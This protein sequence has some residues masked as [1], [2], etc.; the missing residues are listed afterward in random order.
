MIRLTVP[1]I[2]EDDLAAVREVVQSGLL[3]QGP[4]VAAFEEAIAN[5]V[6][7]RYAVAV[8][9]C[10]AALQM[11][12]LALDISR[13][14]IVVTTTYSWPATSNVIELC[15]AEPAFVDIRPDTFNIDPSALDT[16]L[17]QLMSTQST[18][19]RVKAVLPVH[20]FGQVADMPDILEIAGR[21]GLPVVEDAAC[22][23]GAT[24]HGR[25]AGSW[26]MMGCFSFHPRKAITT[27]EGGA[28]TTNDATLVRRLRALRNHGQDPD[29]SSPDFVMPGFNNRM[30]EF[31]G[32]LGSTQMSKLDRVVDAR[33]RAASRYDALLRGSTLKTPHVAPGSRHVYQSYVTL[34][35][36]D[37]APERAAL[38]AAWK[39]D[40][41]ET[42]IGTWHIPM[43]RYYRTRYGYQSGHFPATDD[44]FARALTLPLY[45][46]LSEDDQLSVTETIARALSPERAL[47]ATSGASRS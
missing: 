26:G 8:A 38:I 9:N 27:G 1:S 30:T 13:G 5:L 6:G 34:L 22:A 17:K 2:E 47:G 46:K 43:T 45:E 41:V 23:L 3:V 42:A 4:R 19:R 25:Q 14:D 11:A 29:A 10:T 44:V 39:E 40:G 37:A 35:P 28:I 31:Q 36:E 16:T 12:L 20:A 15:G 24:L 32:A 21:Y 7:T 33:R 18:A